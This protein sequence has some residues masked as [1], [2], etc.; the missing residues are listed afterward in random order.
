VTD[1][2]LEDSDAPMSTRTRIIAGLVG[3]VVILGFAYGMVR[4][5]SRPIRPQQSPPAGHYSL[6]C[7]TCH[8]VSADAPAF[9]VV[10]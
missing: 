1:E 3:S 10:K 6:P 8:T 7:A 5:S 2:R 9:E 4:M